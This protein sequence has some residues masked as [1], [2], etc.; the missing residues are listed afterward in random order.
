MFALVDF[1]GLTLLRLLNQIKC[2]LSI[3]DLVD[4]IDCVFYESVI[5]IDSN[6][7]LGV[8]LCRNL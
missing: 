7:Y 1:H 3:Y 2:R 8:Q 5:D 6:H 4:I